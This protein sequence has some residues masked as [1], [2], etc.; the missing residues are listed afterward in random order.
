[1]SAKNPLVILFHKP[2]GVLSQFTRESGKQSLADFGPFPPE[3]YPVGRLDADSEGVLLLTNDKALKHRLTSPDYGHTK[4]YLVQVERVPGTSALENLR[5]GVMMQGRK[6]RPA[7]VRL[8]EDDPALPERS[9]PIRFRKSVPTAWLEITLTEG[10]NRQI[11]HM[12]AAVGHPTLRL[13]RTGIGSLE[14]GELEPGTSRELTKE[15]IA[16]LEERIGA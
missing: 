1:M 2:F 3:V 13:V 15:E 10:R 8:L 4:T 7:E 12:T 9:V 16:K 11:R 14:L 6:T 5:K